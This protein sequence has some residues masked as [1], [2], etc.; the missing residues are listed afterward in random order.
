MLT[1]NIVQVNSSC[2]VYIIFYY[3]NQSVTL[4]FLQDA[5]D[6]LLG[7]KQTL[8]DGPCALNIPFNLKAL[9]FMSSPKISIIIPVY[10]AESYL[11]RCVDSIITQTFTDWELL[12]VDDGSPDH[13]GE[14]CEKY[15]SAYKSRIK[16]FHKPNGG[17]ASAREFGMQQ[18]RGEY[19][20]HVDPD[21]WIDSNTL[22]ELYQQAVKEQADMVICDF[23]MEYPNRQIHNCQKPQLLDSSSFMHQLLQQER[24]GSLCNKLIRTEL[25]HKYQLHFPEKM[26]CWEDLYICCS[27]LLHGCKL[28][29]VP[30]ALYHYDF[31]TNDNSMVRHTDMRGLQAQI[32]FCRLMQAKISPEYLP[33]LNEL[34]GITLITAFRNQ[35][36]NE[37]AIRSLFPEIND[38]YVTRYGH[39][40]EKSNY[41]GLTLVLRGY[42]F[43][44][45]R[46][47]MFVAKFLVQIKIKLQECYNPQR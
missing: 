37:Q 27:I 41:Y 42:N 17:V 1:K 28:A 11:H 25:Y 14:L 9:I 20:I 22:E 5:F 34:K 6:T 23:M 2:N 30:H 4:V 36:L 18:A 38:W 39:D 29:Y 7:K 44:T 26:I 15:A 16:A 45:A 19:S 24:H 3:T 33:E 21:D 35:L 46:R 8:H 43:K 12:L 47:R 32:D 13:S 40:Y 31:Y 10:M